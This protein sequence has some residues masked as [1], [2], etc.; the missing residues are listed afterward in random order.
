[1]HVGLPPG[2]P[3][4]PPI[5]CASDGSSSPVQAGREEWFGRFFR[6]VASAGAAGPRPGRDAQG[7]DGH[8]LKSK[9]GKEGYKLRKQTVK[10]VFGEVL[11]F[12]RFS[13]RGHAKVSLEWTLISVS[14]NFKR[15]FTLKSQA[16][17]A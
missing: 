8:C 7:E 16:A 4:G 14:D 10:P 5:F 1:M 12:H 9:L 11:G 3:P 2:R 13:L 17:A 15:L 6:P